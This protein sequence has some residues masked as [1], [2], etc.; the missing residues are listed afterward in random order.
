MPIGINEPG[1]APSTGHCFE[2]RKFDEIVKS[3]K[4]RFPV[5]PA[6]AGIQLF[7][8]LKN[9]LDS[10]FHRSDDFL[11]FHQRME[12]W[13]VPFFQSSILRLFGSQLRGDVNFSLPD[14]FY[15]GEKFRVRFFFQKI[16]I[17][18]GNEGMMEVVPAIVHGED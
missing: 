9:S 10:G 8:T 3:Q 5:I 12:Y 16:P 4:V 2:G 15:G 14:F 11:R 17:C 1:K 13:N 18:T 7:Q 6:K